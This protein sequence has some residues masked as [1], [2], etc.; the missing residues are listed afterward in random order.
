MP[1]K[2]DETNPC[3]HGD[4]LF[5]SKSNDL[6]RD[7]ISAFHVG[8]CKNSVMSTFIQMWRVQY[9]L[10]W[11]YIIFERCVIMTYQWLKLMTH[12]QN[13]LNIHEKSI[14]SEFIGC[15]LAKYCPNLVVTAILD[16][17]IWKTAFAIQTSQGHLK[18]AC[19]YHVNNFT[20]SEILV[21]SETENPGKSQ[22]KNRN[23]RQLH[24]VKDRH[25]TW[26]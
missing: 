16:V 8:K 24:R 18:S 7:I 6:K 3:L 4:I 14:Q 20:N 26:S 17:D 15:R 13:L 23:I 25:C 1:S 22:R 9:L 11:I 2:F 12:D 19:I 5:I 21:L 10:T